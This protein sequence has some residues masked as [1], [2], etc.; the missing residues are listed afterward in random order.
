MNKERIIFIVLLVVVGVAAF[1]IGQKTG[2]EPPPAT[3]AATPEG[4]GETREIRQGGFQFT[5]PLL[6]CDCEKPSKLIGTRTL[7]TD[8]RNYVSQVLREGKVSHVSVYFRDMNNGPW[9]G[10][11]E[12]EAFLGGS[13]YKLPLMIA[14]LKM[15]EEN[16][17][18]MKKRV[19][20]KPEMADPTYQVIDDTAK[21]ISGK[22]Y[23]FEDILYR[24]IVYSDNNAKNLVLA[25]VGTE[26]FSKVLNEIQGHV[27]GGRLQGDDITVKGYSS[28]F[29]VLYNASYLSRTM[30]E[31]AL[32]LMAK[33]TYNNGIVAGV[34]EGIVVSHKFGE[35]GLDASTGFQLHD[36]GIV[37]SF[38]SPYLICVMTR[39]T[40]HDELPRVIARISEMVYQSVSTQ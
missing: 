34:P 9:I 30:S 22:T 20:Y 1:F 31:K 5:S 29:R 7:E 33:S 32:G 12:N 26:R 10:L 38:K 35:R 24:M 39:G 13:L 15:A 14:A 21:L 37:Y 18:L 17:Q 28:F 6:D 8:L 19:M 25:E 36:C 40:D 27:G 3:V 4:N 11:G 16:P 2:V 23:V